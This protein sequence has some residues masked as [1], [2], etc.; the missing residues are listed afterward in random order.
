MRRSVSVIV[1][2]VYLAIAGSCAAQ[3]AIR[4]A[5]KV[6]IALGIF[7]APADTATQ[8]TL[9]LYVTTAAAKGRR[10]PGSVRIALPQ[11]L[12]LVS[13]DTAFTAPV[14][15]GQTPRRFAIRAD[16]PGTYELRGLMKLDRALGESDL[17]E[18]SLTVVVEGR[19]LRPKSNVIHRLET[20]SN[21]KRFRMAGQ[22]LVPMEADEVFDN[23]EFQRS[24]TRPQVV[25]G[26]PATCADCEATEVSFAVV[27]DKT[28][29]IIQ[30]NP[31]GHPSPKALE[32][33]KAAMAAW[34]F[35]PAH[36]YD[37]PVT[38]WAQVTVPVTRSR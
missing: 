4:P 38:D 7:S 36:L 37:Q 21:G 19:T 13:G 14:T 34:R 32:A 2:I 25:Q 12:T 20:T 18:V 11:G 31:E 24:G 22:W 15:T 10:G 29:K 35:K 28:G 16:R 33:A 30:M 3:E 8:D 26:P 9:T 23:V 6:A 17:S 27:V 5:G 1:S